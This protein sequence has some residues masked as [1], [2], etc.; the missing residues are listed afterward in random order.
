MKE[1]LSQGKVVLH[2]NVKIKYYPKK[3]EVPTALIHSNG[4]TEQEIIYLAHIFD[5][6]PKQGANDNISGSAAILEIGRAIIKLLKEN[7]G[8]SGYPAARCGVVVLA[9][10]CLRLRNALLRRRI[11]LIARQDTLPRH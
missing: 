3:I 5:T 9:L 11:G 2:A 4:D 7:K 8:L 6:I 1:Q 10:T